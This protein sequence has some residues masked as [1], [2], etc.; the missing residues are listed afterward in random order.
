MELS[1]AVVMVLFKRNSHIVRQEGA[2][3]PKEDSAF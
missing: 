3:F 2:V 1:T